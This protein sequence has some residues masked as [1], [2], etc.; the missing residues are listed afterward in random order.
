[1]HLSIIYHIWL[2]GVNKKPNPDPN[3]FTMSNKVTWVFLCFYRRTIMAAEVSR[4]LDCS[5]SCMPFSTAESEQCLWLPMTLNP[6]TLWLFLLP[7]VMRTIQLLCISDLCG[8]M[9]GLVS[10]TCFCPVLI[11]LFIL[12]HFVILAAFLPTIEKAVR[13]G[14]PQFYCIVCVW[15]YFPLLFWCHS[16]L[17]PNKGQ[18]SHK[19]PGRN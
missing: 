7:Y 12:F 9:K 19:T 2:H 5:S 16:V 11:H 4:K 17:S 15:P 18:T 8:G 1:M 14:W 13:K 10:T 6:S 3:S